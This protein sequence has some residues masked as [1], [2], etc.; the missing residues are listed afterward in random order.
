[1]REPRGGDDLKNVPGPKA[2]FLR[3]HQLGLSDNRVRDDDGV[4]RGRLTRVMAAFDD[5]DDRRGERLGHW[6]T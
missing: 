6:R 3:N 1:M 4:R 2:E 5:G